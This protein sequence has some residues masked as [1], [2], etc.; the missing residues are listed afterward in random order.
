[1][2]QDVITHKT[3][4]CLDFISTIFDIVFS[5]KIHFGLITMQGIFG[6]IKAKGQ[7]FNSQV[8]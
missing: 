5:F 4:Q 8:E 7:C 3:I 6:H 1:V 2:S